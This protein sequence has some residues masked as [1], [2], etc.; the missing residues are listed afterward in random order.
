MENSGLL[1]FQIGQDSLGLW[2]MFKNGSSSVPRHP[3]SEKSCARSATLHPL[4]TLYHRPAGWQETPVHLRQPLGKLAS[5]VEISE[6][7]TRD[8]INLKHLRNDV[9]EDLIVLMDQGHFVK[10]DL[11]NN[12]DHVLFTDGSSLVEDGISGAGYA[13]TME[14]DVVT[15]SITQKH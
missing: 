13:V 7:F 8:S 4:P 10:E 12:P 1:F 11:L 3:A 15:A 9:C 14:H 5:R 6:H 2:S